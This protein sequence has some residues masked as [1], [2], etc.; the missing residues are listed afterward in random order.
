VD[1][2][3]H[4]SLFFTSDKFYSLQFIHPTDELWGVIA[5]SKVHCT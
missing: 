2:Y 1:T 3:I 5:I 4:H